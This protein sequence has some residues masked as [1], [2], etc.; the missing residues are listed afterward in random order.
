MEAYVPNKSPS[1]IVSM[2]ILKAYSANMSILLYC[3]T[4]IIPLYQWG[5]ILTR[6]TY[7]AI[8]IATGFSNISGGLAIFG[9][10]VGS[11]SH[12]LI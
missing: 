9:F 5:R 6:G 2:T 3:S 1:L 7:Q 10:H 8:K 4:I 11:L 12:L